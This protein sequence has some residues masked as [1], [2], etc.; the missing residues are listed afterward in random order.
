MSMFNRREFLTGLT[1]ASVVGWRRI[2]VAAGYPAYWGD[3]L[4][5]AVARTRELSKTCPD[6]FWFMTDLH[7]RHN[8][9]QSGGLLA[10]L[11]RASSL[12]KVICGGDIPV[13]FADGF[14]SDREA[15]DFAI[16]AYREKWVSPIRGNGGKIYTA[17]GNHDFTV[18]HSIKPTEDRKAGFTYDGKTARKIIMTDSTERDVVTNTADPTACYYYFDNPSAK[19]RYI[20]ADSSDSERAGDVAWGIVQEMHETQLS[21]LAGEAFATV[22]DDYSVVV[23][24]HIPVSAALDKRYAPLY[25]LLKAYQNRGVYKI[26]KRT[27][28]FKDARGRIILDLTGHKHCN[29]ATFEG[30]VLQV[31]AASDAYVNDN[32]AVWWTGPTARKNAG[33]ATEQAF[34]A[35]QLDPTRRLVHCTHV[36]GGGHDRMYHLDAA[37]VEAGEKR[38]FVTSLTGPITWLCHDADR[39]DNVKSTTKR[40]LTVA[41]PRHEFATIDSNGTL[42]AAAPGEVMVLAR[43]ADGTV[44]AFPVTVIARKDANGK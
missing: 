28:S 36:G 24:H 32:R 3:S 5:R 38:P 35:I 42:T 4:A 44:E 27:F 1:A 15:V 16:S 8:A 25:D 34:D 30:G 6:G 13:A 23:V 17:K 39:V 22:P 26:G 18:R 43:N 37:T 29:M 7:I 12:N 21:W 11:V 41:H 31:T 2:A 10:E 40:F 20:V 9:C 33:S 14:P 19:I